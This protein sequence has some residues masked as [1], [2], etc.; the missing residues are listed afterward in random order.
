MF[1]RP[2]SG[3]RALLVQLAIG[4]PVDADTVLEFQL[5]A[6]AAGAIEV[7]WLTGTRDRYYAAD[8]NAKVVERL[9][10]SGTE[11]EAEALD[12]EHALL[13]EVAPRVAAWLSAR[14]DPE[15]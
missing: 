12:L 8:Y 13:D 4:H 11:L 5:L 6:K 10:A 9:A 1:E 7:G 15:A 3:E 2:K 14:F